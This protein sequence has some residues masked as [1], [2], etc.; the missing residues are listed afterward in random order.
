MQIFRDGGADAPTEYEGPREAA[1][2]VTHLR[3]QAGPPS[4]LLA[5][6]AAVKAFRAFT[7]DKDTVGERLQPKLD[8]SQC[9]RH[10]SRYTAC[11]AQHEHSAWPCCPAKGVLCR[12][13]VYP[14]SLDIMEPDPPETATSSSSQ[15]MRELQQ[16]SNRLMRRVEA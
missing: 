1:G 16:F 11:C 7:D 9:N 13:A 12:P 2:I 8:C 10:A 6:A 5:D 15:F 4:L 14:I 3:K